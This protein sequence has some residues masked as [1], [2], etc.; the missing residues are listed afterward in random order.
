MHDEDRGP[1]CHDSQLNSSQTGKL[2]EGQL[3]G[4]GSKPSAT[5]EVKMENNASSLFER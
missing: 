3:V 1:G 4:E 2:G 5:V